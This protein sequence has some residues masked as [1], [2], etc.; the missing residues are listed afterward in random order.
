MITSVLER[1]K[2]IGTMKA[3][4]AKNSEILKIFLFESAFLGFIAGVTGASIGFLISFT[5]KQI[6]LNLGWGFLSPAFPWY[7]FIGAIA[8]ATLTGAL[9]GIWPAWRASKLKTVDALRYE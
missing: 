4:G 1:T 9:S 7:L 2:E 3:V 5:A 6:L 8:F